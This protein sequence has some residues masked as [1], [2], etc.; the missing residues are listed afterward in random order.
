MN[1]F[2]AL[3]SKIFAGLSAVL[4]IVVAVLWWRLGNANERIE[5]LRQEN[6]ACEAARAVQNAAIAQAGAEA[7]AQREAYAQALSDGQQAIA[8][9]QGRVRVVRQTAPNACETPAEIMGAGL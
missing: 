9:A 5:A 2:S 4:L 3:T 7:A 6:A 8:E 1:P